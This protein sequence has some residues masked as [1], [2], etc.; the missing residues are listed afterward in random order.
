MLGLLAAGLAVG[1]WPGLA[2]ATVEAATRF[3][4]RGG[5]AAAVLHGA[6]LEDIRSA[7]ASVPAWYDWLYAALSVAAAAA[8]ALLSIRRPLP[9]GVGARPIEVLRGLHSGHPGDYVAFAT[10]GTA[11]LGALFAV[12]LT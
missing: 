10:A 9:P 4:D 8:L 2:D 11:L 6:P 3:L 5:F 1:I 7:P 12:T